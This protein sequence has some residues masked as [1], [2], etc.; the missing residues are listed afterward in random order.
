MKRV[1][2]AVTI[3][4]S[5]VFLKL[6]SGYPP[7]ALFIHKSNVLKLNFIDEITLFYLFHHQ[8]TLLAK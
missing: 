8:H 2:V 5:T 6:I 7:V 4:S 3:Y 1:S